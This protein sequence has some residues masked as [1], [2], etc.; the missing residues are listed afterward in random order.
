MSTVMSHFRPVPRGLRADATQSDPPGTQ[1]DPLDVAHEVL[2]EL[3]ADQRFSPARRREIRGEI[4]CRCLPV[5]RGLAR[6]YFRCGAPIE[7]LVQVATIG[8]INAIDRFDAQRGTHFGAFAIPTITGEL[9]RYLRDTA[10]ALRVPR[11]LQEACL[12][13]SRVGPELCQSLGRS[14]TDADV[15]RRLGIALEEVRAA[16][17]ATAAYRAGTD[18]LEML[19]A[20]DNQESIRV[21][22]LD[23]P[24][25]DFLVEIVT[26]RTLVK[27]LPLDAKTLLELRFVGGLSQREI[28]EKVGRSQGGVSRMLAAV[29]TRLR[30]G[31]VSSF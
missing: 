11:R 5:A 6:R 26:L 9:R 16:R 13:V 24:E 14:P 22:G 8:L 19:L 4:I 30:R 25:P 7:D 21:V 12:E 18:S 1:P 29:L 17:A 2:C 3:A 20:T 10:W 28:A 31:M 15:A 27:A 23:E